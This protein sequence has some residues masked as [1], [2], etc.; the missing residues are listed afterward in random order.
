MTR[1]RALQSSQQLPQWALRHGDRLSGNDPG[2][3][4]VRTSARAG[5]P[6]TDRQ[7]GRETVSAVTEHVEHVAVRVADEEAADPPGFVGEG[8]HN[9]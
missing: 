2:V 4:Q 5:F 9:L 1:A 6:I 3:T 7:L 8:V